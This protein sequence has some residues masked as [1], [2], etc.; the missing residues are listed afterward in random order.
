FRHFLIDAAPHPHIQPA[1]LFNL[2][3]MNGDAGA[4]RKLEPIIMRGEVAA[5]VWIARGTINGEK[6][7]FVD[8]EDSSHF[9]ESFR[10]GTPAKDFAV[11]ENN[12]AS[13]LR[14]GQVRLSFINHGTLP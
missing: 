4:A 2:M 9:H 1:E 14:R 8:A 5:I 7:V 6:S 11:V 3:G 10:G 13:R 12:C